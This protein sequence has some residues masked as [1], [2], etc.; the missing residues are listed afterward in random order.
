MRGDDT[1]LGVTENRVIKPTEDAQES[2]TAAKPTPEEGGRGADSSDTTPVK[3]E[4]SS[5]PA[6][7]PPCDPAP[8]L[9]EEVNKCSDVLAD[10]QDSGI[11]GVG[12]AQGGN[13]NKNTD[14]SG[15][16]DANN[17]DDDDDDL[18]SSV[19]NSNN[20]WAE[21]EAGERTGYSG[22]A[23]EPFAVKEG[24]DGCC[25]MEVCGI[26]G[27]MGIEGQQW[28]HTKERARPCVERRLYVD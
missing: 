3:T 13:C 5:S 21:V 10:A 4:G 9:A 17:K 23:V 24:I 19:E 12:Q 1:G 15:H 16:G 7:A 26:A 22:A 18:S 2:G 27:R 6:A 25:I 8:S 11:A 28:T 14:D 20:G